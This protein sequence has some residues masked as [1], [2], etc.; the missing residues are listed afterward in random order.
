M[1]SIIILYSN[2]KYLHESGINSTMGAHVKQE[3]LSGYVAK[4]KTDSVKQKSPHDINMI[5]FAKQ[6]DRLFYHCHVWG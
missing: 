6:T 4:L 2:T 3:Y 5:M 1:R